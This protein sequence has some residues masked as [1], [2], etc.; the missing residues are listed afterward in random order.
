MAVFTLCIF[1]LASLSGNFELT[2]GSSNETNYVETLI[3][4]EDT[5]CKSE[6]LECDDLC[7]GPSKICNGVSECFSGVDENC[8]C[9]SNE[10]A[11]NETYSATQ[12]IDVIR[13]C[14]RKEDCNNGADELECDTYTCPTTHSK[15]GN[16]F[17]IPR[18]AWC[19]FI[20]DCGDFSDE[21]K[22]DHRKCYS[23]EFTCSNG[24]CIKS[25]FMCDNN[26]DCIDGSDE[27]NCENH[28][29]CDNGLY[30]P[31]SSL[32]CDKWV[33]CKWT[34][35]DELNCDACSGPEDF[36]CN[37]GRCIRASNVCDG[38]CDC[39]TSCDD[40]NECEFTC[41]GKFDCSSRQHGN[42]ADWR[43]G[44]CI[45]WKFVCD[46]VNDCWDSGRGRDESYCKTPGDDFCRNSNAYNND[47]RCIGNCLRSNLVCNYVKDCRDGRDEVGCGYLDI[48]C[49]KSEFMCHSGQCVDESLRCDGV[50]HCLDHSDETNCGDHVCRDDQW[51]CA[52]GQCL[53][54]SQVCDYTRDCF[55]NS[56]ENN[57]NHK[58][59]TSVEFRCRSGQCIPNENVCHQS[60]NGCID[61][62]HLLNCREY[63]CDSGY[64]KCTN[65]YCIPESKK[66]DDV[67]DCEL[68]LNDEAQEVCKKPYAC[69]YPSE[70]CTC[71]WKELNCSFQ[72]LVMLPVGLK[73][74]IKVSEFHLSGNN[75]ILN[76][77]TFEKW[78]KLTYLDLSRNN[79]SYI[80]A[81]VFKQLWRL[82]ELNL[83]DNYISSITQGS[84]TGLSSLSKLTLGGNSISSIQR[85]GF[86]GLSSLGILDL[87]HQN[88]TAVHA[89]SFQGLR[90]LRNLDLSYNRITHI[91]DGAFNGLQDLLKLTISHNVIVT[92][93]ENAFNG[94]GKLNM[95][96]TDEFKFCCLAKHVENCNPKPDEF[97]SCEDLMSNFVLRASIWILGTVACLGNLVVVIWRLKEFRGSK[98]HSFL[99]TNLA[100]GDFL[101]GLYLLII[102]SVDAF[103]RGHY[104]VYHDTWRKSSMCNFA[105]FL[106]TF[107]CEISVFTL[108]VITLDRLIVIIFPFKAKRMSI[109]QARGVMLTAWLVVS[110]LAGLPLSN[111]PYFKDFY[112][113]SG[114]CLALHIT[115]DKPNGWEYSVFIFLA[116]NMVS[117]LFIASSYISMFIVAKRTQGAVRSQEVKNDTKLARRMTL[118]VMTDFCCWVPIILLGIISLMGFNIHSQIY[119]WVAVFV[120]P[121]NSALN[122]VIYTISTAPFLK[123]ARLLRRSFMTKDTSS[124]A[125]DASSHPGSGFRFK[126]SLHHTSVSRDHSSRPKFRR[127]YVALKQHPGGSQHNT[128]VGEGS[129]KRGTTRLA[130]ESTGNTEIYD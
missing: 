31:R 27:I 95:L 52:N 50:S 84:F 37:N 85:S 32:I 124:T 45:D 23:Q 55:D 8:G 123:R 88:L 78:G 44:R 109:R 57:C 91:S 90:Q 80:P 66:C 82:Q 118:I 127:D 106:S 12:C 121:L 94:L 25:A 33:D 96:T 54:G 129:I 40:E 98:I 108:T 38:V 122:P 17:C 113:R 117:F 26:T 87:R 59:C 64:F 104:I 14:D 76:N 10:F 75:L 42:I 62:S 61:H 101:M 13:R 19:N 107:S 120:L 53:I 35:L 81:G 89:D 73:E 119:A 130:N 65:S 4:G 114:V 6:E 15:C 29:Y 111:A 24:E 51:Q 67:V 43:G 83:G 72:G 115:H 22:C 103:Y 69:P 34:Q 86:S 97:S 20:D 102:A 9:L 16:H 41:V 74:E 47:L 39:A 3:S 92:I 71:H 79:L 116:L 100:I 21:S 99:I 125:A 126:S 68:S 63:V 77:E 105:G 18:E 48:P 46:G 110:F 11:C 5:V 93:G 56:D 49:S 36:Q 58:N 60:N 128:S 70:E 30:I 1:A 7:L 112:G 2:S 28:F